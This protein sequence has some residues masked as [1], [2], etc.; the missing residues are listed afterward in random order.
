MCNNICAAGAPCAGG[1]KAEVRHPH[2]LSLLNEPPAA[3]TGITRLPTQAR[4]SAR[5]LNRVL[6]LRQQRVARHGPRLQRVQRRATTHVTARGAARVQRTERP[7]HL[8]R[9]VYTTR[10]EE[11]RPRG[12]PVHRHHSAHVRGQHGPGPLGG[13]HV[14][15]LRPPVSRQRAV[16]SRRRAPGGREREEAHGPGPPRCQR[17]TRRSEGPTAGIRRPAPRS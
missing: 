15:D 10:R 5:G 11:V 16:Q 12:V 6:R 7:P 14:E 13:T 17:R 1:G 4:H 2:R 8:D 3:R 9:A